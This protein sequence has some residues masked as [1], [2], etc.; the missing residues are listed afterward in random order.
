MTTFVTSVKV[1][2]VIPRETFTGS[3]TPPARSFQTTADSAR[4]ARVAPAGAGSALVAFPSSPY[5]SG[6]PPSSIPA[7]A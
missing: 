5:F 3:R 1:W 7:R 4:P 6:E 2:S